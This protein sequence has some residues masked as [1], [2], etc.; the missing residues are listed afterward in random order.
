MQIIKDNPAFDQPREKLK[1]FFLR[2]DLFY[3]RDVH[4]CFVCGN[5]SELLDGGKRRSLRSTFVEY[6]QDSPHSKIICVRAETAATELLRQL[7][8]RGKSISGFERT[9]AETVDSVL[10]FPE[11]AGSIAELG[12]FSAHRGVAEKTLVAITEKYQENSFIYLGPIHLVNAFSRYAPVPFVMAEP[13]KQQMRKIAEKLLGESLNKRPYRER[14]EHDAWKSI[15]L[16]HKLAIIDELIDIVRA[17]TEPD[18]RNYIEICFGAYDISEIRLLLSILVATRRIE[19]NKD[20]DIFSR[21]R[22]QKFLE[23]DSETAD[24]SL[25]VEWQ[26]VLEE[27]MPDAITGLQVQGE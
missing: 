2:G 19:R 20:G 23:C 18:L 9:I 15:S 8:E 6:I 7:E 4:L 22:Q 3:C 14:F 5:S 26:V 25:R 21:A 1:E 27:N 13:T 24:E 16:R 17:S 10:I 11:S 12:Y